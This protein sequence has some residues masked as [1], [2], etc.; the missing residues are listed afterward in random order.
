M[1]RNSPMKTQK[2]ER[3]SQNENDQC[4]SPSRLSSQGKKEQVVLY[5]TF[6]QDSSCLAIGTRQ[7]FKIY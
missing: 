4:Q 5:Y 3:S 6:N 7:G 2:I 1:E